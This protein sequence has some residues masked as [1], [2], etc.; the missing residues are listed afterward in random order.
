MAEITGK[1]KDKEVVYQTI[2]VYTTKNKRLRI[3]NKRLASFYLLKESFL[4]Y[5]VFSRSSKYTI[6]E[7]TYD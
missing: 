7:I 2:V 6:D 1:R 3:R 4:N 5:R